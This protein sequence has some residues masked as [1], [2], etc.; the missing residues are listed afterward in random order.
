MSKK[1]IITINIIVLTIAVLAVGSRWLF[2]TNEKQSQKR[3]VAAGQEFSRRTKITRS[4]E[5][6]VFVGDTHGWTAPWVALDEFLG[7]RIN[8]SNL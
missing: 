6:L 1:T 4:H 5:C 8:D 3:C 7:A 2:V